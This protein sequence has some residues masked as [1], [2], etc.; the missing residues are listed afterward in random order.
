LPDRLYFLWTGG[1][2]VWSHIY[3][4]VFSKNIFTAVLFSV[5][6]GMTGDATVS[7]TSGLVGE[8]FSI[9]MYLCQSDE[10]EDLFKWMKESQILWQ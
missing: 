8:N 4:F 7:P 10:Y 1:R 5:G 2:A 9:I 6:L 3:L